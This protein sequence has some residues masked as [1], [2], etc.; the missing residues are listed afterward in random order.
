MTKVFDPRTKIIFVFFFTAVAIF[1]GNMMVLNITLVIGVCFALFFRVRLVPLFK[2]MQKFL[3]FFLV[4]IIIQSIFVAEGEVIFRLFGVKLLTDVGIIRGVQYLYRMLVVIL[5]GAIIS[6]S[7]LKDNLQA[8][9]QLG[10]PY[11]VGFMCAIGIRFLPIFMEDIKNTQMA[12]GLRGIDFESLKLTDRI[13]MV[14]TLFL[15]TVVG[16]L[17]RA[18]ELSLSAEARGYKIQSKRSYYRWL[19]F[20]AM[21]YGMIVM[22]MVLFIGLVVWKG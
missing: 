14:T 12:L 4:L 15:P 22:V 10:L 18:K 1:F 8:L 9:V 11:D 5:S 19:K 3:R 13:Q 16:A 6:T 20:S 17:Q 21:D 2:R 7:G